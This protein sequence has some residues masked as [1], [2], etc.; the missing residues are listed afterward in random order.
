MIYS[1]LILLTIILGAVCSENDFTESPPVPGISLGLVGDSTDVQTISKA[2]TVIM[3]GS[4]DVDEAIL[5]MINNSG[6]GDFVVIRAKGTDAYN[7]YIFGLGDIN[8]VETLLIDSRS[9]A[10]DAGVVR[11]VR[12]AEALFI[13]GGNQYD[14]VSFWK[15]TPLEEAINYLLND[16]KVPIGGTSAGAAIMGEFYFDAA[17]G[18]IYSDEALENP[19]DSLISIQ[20]NDFIENEYLI[21]T[22]TDTHYS[23]RDRQ[24]RHTTFIARIINDLNRPARGIGVDE[25]T[26][27]CIDENGIATVFG[28]NHVYFIDGSISNPEIISENE[29]LHW[30]NQMRALKVFKI[31]GSETGNQSFD[32]KSWDSDDQDITGYWYVEN[33]TFE[34]F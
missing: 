15:D 19:F 21:N 25:R 31:Q 34:G 23:Q 20:G 17:K 30:Y 10:S 33:G 14:Y 26:A 24:G 32:L 2:G 8:S 9:D 22:I 7:D 4:R 29:P 18:T 16:K 3:G 28:T 27:V 6:G 1:K 12:D 11:K 13:A 5:W